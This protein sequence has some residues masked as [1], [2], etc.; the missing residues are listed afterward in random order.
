MDIV[1]ERIPDAIIVPARALFTRGGKPT[2]HLVVPDGFQTVEV[3]ILA[4]NP[5][6]IAVRGVA[7]DARVTLVDPFAGGSDE[8]GAAP[9]GVE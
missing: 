7:A 9:G 4:R 6:E 2:V 5:D 3:E 1:I 8:A